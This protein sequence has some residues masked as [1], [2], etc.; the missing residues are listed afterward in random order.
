VILI[1]VFS[2]YATIWNELNI[3][4]IFKSCKLRIP[5]SR[6]CGFPWSN[7]HFL[8]L[9]SSIFWGKI[10]RPEERHWWKQ[11]CNA[12]V[13]VVIFMK[14]LFF[15]SCIWNEINIFFKYLFHANCDYRAH[16]HVGPPGQ[17]FISMFFLSPFLKRL[18][19]RH[20]EI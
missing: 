19:P 10:C 14:R 8:I 15:C 17:I 7:F 6:P 9:S 2:V 5:G 1:V 4:K 18:I 3:F 13:I 12:L 11:L 16:A 20:E